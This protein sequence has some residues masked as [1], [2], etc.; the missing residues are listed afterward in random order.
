VERVLARRGQRSDEQPDDHG[1]RSP[2][3][4]SLSGA[5]RESARVVHGNRGP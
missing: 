5:A 2:D 3:G 4:G 1:T